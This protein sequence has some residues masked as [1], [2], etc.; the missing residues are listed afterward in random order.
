MPLTYHK[1]KW[2]PTREIC[3]KEKSLSWHERRKN[4]H[5][6]RVNVKKAK[7]AKNSCSAQHYFPS[8][9]SSDLKMRPYCLWNTEAWL[10]ASWTDQLTAFDKTTADLIIAQR[11]QEE[12]CLSLTIFS[13]SAPPRTA[14]CCTRAC[15]K[16][17]FLNHVN[18]NKEKLAWTTIF[19]WHAVWGI[20]VMPSPGLPSLLLHVGL[21]WSLFHGLFEESPCCIAC[22]CWEGFGSVLS[23]TEQTLQ[24]PRN[25]KR[26]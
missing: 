26:G 4:R 17:R 20:W 2:N 14:C 23:V 5:S 22:H 21:H 3:Q 7:P 6:I 1:Q 16:V 19:A 10:W 24:T 25:L 18:N 9:K 8:H 13:S 15:T 12:K 11:K